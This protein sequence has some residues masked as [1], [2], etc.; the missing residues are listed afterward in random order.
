MRKCCCCHCSRYF[1]KEK[2]ATSTLSS[3]IKLKN[4]KNFLSFTLFTTH[5]LY[6]PIALS[7]WNVSSRMVIQ[8]L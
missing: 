3:Q 1:L 4:K 7:Y 2:R 8:T 6:P 5:L